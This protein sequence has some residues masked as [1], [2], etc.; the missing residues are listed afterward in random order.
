MAAMTTQ[1]HTS[2]NHDAPNL[3]H[4]RLRQL[5][6]H[7]P[8]AQLLIVQQQLLGLLRRGGGGENGGG[9]CW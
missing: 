8:G 1:S 9:S 4:H 6:R 3:L 5:L 7:E 2:I